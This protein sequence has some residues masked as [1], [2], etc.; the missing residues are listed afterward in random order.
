MKEKF[1]AYLKKIKGLWEIEE[2]DE[3][4]FGEAFLTGVCFILAM[5]TYFALAH[6]LFIYMNGVP[7]Q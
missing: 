7:P 3:E 5:A 4:S 6:L 1:A 2:E